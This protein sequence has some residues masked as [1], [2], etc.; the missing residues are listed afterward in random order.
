L[1]GVRRANAADEKRSL[2]M[3]EELVTVVA[4]SADKATGAVRTGE[5]Q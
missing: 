2:A 3:G 4:S 5:L 1:A